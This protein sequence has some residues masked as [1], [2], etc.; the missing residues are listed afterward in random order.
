MR[1]HLRLLLT[2]L[3][4]VLALPNQLLAKGNFVVIIDPG[5]G[6]GDTGTPHRKCK[7][8][9]KTI[10]LNVA[11]RLGKLIEQNYS[12][13]KVVYTRKT[14]KYPTLPDRTEIA[15]KNKGNLFISIHVNACPNSQARGFETYIFGT[16][17]S[18]NGIKRLDEQ[19]VEERE[20]LDFI[21]G[22][23]INF[24]TD[25]DIET[26]IF[27][28]A[29]RE[30]HSKQSK[31]V[32]GYVQ[33]ALI[34]A[35]RKTSYGSSVS[36]RGVR[37]KNLFVLCYSP[38]PAILVELGYMS[39]L[40]EERFINTDEAQSC[41]AQ[42]IYT[43]FT[44]FKRDWDKRQLSNADRTEQEVAEPEAATPAPTESHN[45]PK[46][47]ASKQP[48][49]TG[50]VSWRVQFLSS[51][52]L[53]KEGSREFK[54]LTGVQHYRDGKVYRYTYGSAPTSKALNAD[55]KKVQKLFPDAFPVKFD[56]NGNR[57]KN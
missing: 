24:D 35:L 5:H 32:A 51:D 7:Q 10:A 25:V 4:L 53:L 13:V 22:K 37:G 48:A 15:K 17:G 31:E 6:G 41:F 9:E 11:L 12:D 45:E 26:K 18:S 21:S 56:G 46:T 39:N 30:K 8:D 55:L 54:G 29:M 34:S 44:K 40:A 20:N 38:M 14:D 43:G 47:E 33:N 19:L 50:S 28:Q 42:A 27:C 2:F 52:K 16:D 36:N 1:L 23:Q 49:T 3:M 57:I